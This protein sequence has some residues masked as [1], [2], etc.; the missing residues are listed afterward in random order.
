[1]HDRLVDLGYTA[2][3]GNRYVF[4]RRTIDLLVPSGTGAFTSELRGE[5]MFDAAP[6]LLLD[7]KSPHLTVTVFV[8][9]TNGAETTYR[10][11]VPTVERAVIMKSDALASRS[12]VKDLVDLYNLLLIARA[13]SAEEIGGWKLGEQNLTATRLDTARNLSVKLR[14]PAIR[15]QLAGSAIQPSYLLA[16]A[17][18][19]IPAMNA[20]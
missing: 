1:M 4:D 3:K 12:E 7:P 17:Q 19:M 10:V 8:V 16:L 9:F 2:E 5:R 14:S 20:R 13:Y 15:R 11:R 6:G 18:A